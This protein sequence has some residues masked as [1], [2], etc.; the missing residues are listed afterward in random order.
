MRRLGAQ[1]NPVQFSGV[2]EEYNENPTALIH[3]KKKSMRRAKEETGN[4]G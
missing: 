2:N 3:G 1:G 4:E